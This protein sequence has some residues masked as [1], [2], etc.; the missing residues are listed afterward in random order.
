MFA[1]RAPATHHTFLADEN[2]RNQ[3]QA[4]TSGRKRTQT[5]A[6]GRRRVQTSA[7]GR[8][9]AQAGANETEWSY[10]DV[11]FRFHCPTRFSHPEVIIERFR[12]IRS[13]PG[14]RFTDSSDSTKSGELKKR[15][16]FSVNGE[17]GLFIFYSTFF[18][19]VSIDFTVLFHVRRFTRG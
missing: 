7:S 14:P 11:R 8:E 3:T 9:L 10:T 13:S 6:S 17:F 16:L 15:L 1:L 2:K 4:N 12:F 5:G 19:T 18:G